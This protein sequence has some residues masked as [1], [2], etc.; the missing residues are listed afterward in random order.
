[1]AYAALPISAEERKS[2]QNLNEDVGDYEKIL[3]SPEIGIGR[4][5]LKRNTSIIEKLTNMTYNTTER[6]DD[7]AIVQSLADRAQD[8]SPNAANQD[9]GSSA[10]KRR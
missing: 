3:N 4:V 10:K 2:T 6:E 5:G 7:A 8:I 1:M 9:K